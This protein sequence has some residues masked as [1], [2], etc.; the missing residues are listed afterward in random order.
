MT[1]CHRCRLSSTMYPK[2][3]TRVQ[4]AH[5]SRLPKTPRTP[6]VVDAML[7]LSFEYS[8]V[9]LGSCRSP[10]LTALPVDIPSQR[11][12]TPVCTLTSKLFSLLINPRNTLSVETIWTSQQLVGSSSSLVEEAEVMPSKLSA[13]SKFHQRQS[14]K[15]WRL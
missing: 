6:V 4:G 13:E 1:R 3:V 11:V 7:D 15:K 9:F 2:P 10:P 12:S 14:W 8:V 5:D